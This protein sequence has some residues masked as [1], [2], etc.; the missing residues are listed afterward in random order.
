M[1][2][3]GDG[4]SIGLVGLR[5]LLLSPRE[6]GLHLL[7]L[8][9]LEVILLDTEVR[10]D[11]TLVGVL[12]AGVLSGVHDVH[13]G[14]GKHILEHDLLTDVA[15]A[16]ADIIVDGLPLL[17][18]GGEEEVVGTTR[19]AHDHSEVI[20]LYAIGRDVEPALGLQ[21]HVAL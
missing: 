9:G 1:V 11:S 13:L 5:R 10:T 21:G 14:I 4:I 16:D 2:N 6:E 8:G 20:T 12:R 18:F 3:R 19:E 7:L 15:H 17:Y